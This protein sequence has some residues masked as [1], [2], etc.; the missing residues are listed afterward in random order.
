M[1][2]KTLIGCLIMVAVSLLLSGC[3]SREYQVTLES[4]PGQAGELEGE[5]TY[6]EGE[7]VLVE[8]QEKKGH[9]FKRWTEEGEK[10]STAEEYVFEIKDHKELQAHFEK[11]NYKVSAEIIEEDGGTVEG[12]GSFA[13]GEKVSLEA[14]PEQGYDFIEWIVDGERVSE[15][16]VYEFKVTED[17]H[18]K[19]KFVY[20]NQ[21]ELLLY[22]EKAREALHQKNWTEAGKYLDKL[23]EA[24]GADE[25]PM[26]QEVEEIKETVGLAVPEVLKKE[27][28]VTSEDMTRGLEELEEM[29]PPAPEEE[30]LEKASDELFAWVQKLKKWEDEL[31][32]LPI[33]LAQEQ[34]YSVQ[35]YKKGA[36][37]EARAAA[38]NYF[39]CSLPLLEEE[40]YM[41]R[42]E[43]NE[44]IFYA[45]VPTAYQEDDILLLS[46]VISEPS[47]DV[48]EEELLLT[49]QLE[50]PANGLNEISPGKFRLVYEINQREDDTFRVGKYEILKKKNGEWETYNRKPEPGEDFNG[51]IVKR[52][53]S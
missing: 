3:L 10:V 39:K 42:L 34:G 11:K 46:G 52:M 29:R 32:F 9:Q 37:D 18:L 22:T 44:V 16:E 51:S 49:L 17:K 20:E 35:L 5:G 7:K 43:L 27:W 25:E 30:V 21:E 12:E 33:K 28:I 1:L 2:R 8:A 41:K 23:M 48:T 19:A 36:I 38:Q 40:M 31:M 13:F 47:V 15:K 45:S 6:E 14:T 26:V 50:E 4:K 24:P 53:L